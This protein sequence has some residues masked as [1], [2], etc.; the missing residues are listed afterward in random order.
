MALTYSAADA[1]L[2]EDYKG[3]L[4]S[5]LNNANVL[6]AQLERNSED[7]VGRRAHLPVQVGRNKG[8][9]ARGELEDLPAAGAQRYDEVLVPLRFNYS[10]IAL[11]GPIMRAMRSDRGSFIRA[12]KSETKG[13]LNDV[14][15]DVN[16]Q[17]W[18]TSNGVVAQCG[19]TTAANVVV[20]ASTTT[21]TQ[22]RQLEEDMRIDIGTVAS[23]TTIAESRNITAVDYTN[24]TITIDG[25]AVTTSS[26]HFIFRQG[27][28]GASS[29]SG[30]PNDGQKELTGVQHIV[31]DD[32]TLFT[33]NPASEPKWK[34]YVDTAGSNRAISEDLLIKAM[35]ET[36]IRSGKTPNL[37][38][39]SPGIHRTYA[40]LLTTLKRFPATVAMKGGYSGVDIS[41]VGEGSRSGE[42]VGLV[43]ERDAPEHN[44]WGLST[45]DL[46]QFEMSDW[47][48]M[49]ED[50]A[51][52][53]RIPDQDGYEATLFKYHEV[54]TQQRNAHFRIEAITEP[55]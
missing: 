2:R 35:Q 55:A 37:I 15:R 11:S 14:K 10:R 48:W 46:V 5:Q 39:M 16:R 12:L 18:G 3:P 31:D 7:V 41:W 27:A 44:V 29:G 6:L 42:T 53:S 32:S 51:V 47:E 1:V 28:G 20:L 49:D 36:E 9:G 33:I 4:R 52:L 43:W 38:V 21:R 25:A 30:S 8:V 26:L 17:M 13:L 23:P 50:G 54:A 45:S 19:V 22:L 40:A 24:K 34:A